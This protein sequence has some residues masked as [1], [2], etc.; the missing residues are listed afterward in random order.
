VTGAFAGRESHEVE[1]LITDHYLDALLAAHA[2][3]AEAGPTAEMPRDSIR[4]AADRL[5][6]DLPRFHPSFRFEESL[7]ARLAVA[8]ARMRS[9]DEAGAPG[10]DPIPTRFARDPWF[11][12]DE[13]GSTRLGADRRPLIIGG[14]LTSA[15]LS[16]AGAA[17][18]AWRRS[19]PPDSPMARAARA[20]A[21]TRPA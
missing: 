8:A 4:R 12:P 20:V 16:L 19:R 17:Y 1:A 7:A 18:V 6:R 3:G 9:A 15:A 21:R 5:A 2:R 11:L 13:P 10:T 14:A